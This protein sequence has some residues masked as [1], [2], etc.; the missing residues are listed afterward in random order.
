MTFKELS[1]ATQQPRADYY[2]LILSHS[3]LIIFEVA[4]TSKAKVAELLHMKPSAFSG[5]YGCIVA[6]DNI[7]KGS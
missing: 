2:E 7:I 3:T 1:K 5:V 6:H 4:K